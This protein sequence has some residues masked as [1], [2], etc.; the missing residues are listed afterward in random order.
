MNLVQASPMREKVMALQEVMRELPQMP[1]QTSHYF[2]DG[3]YARE[4]A[5][6]EGSLVVGKVHKREHLFI[7]LKG[8]LKVTIEDEVLVLSAPT[9]LVSKAGAKRALLALEDSIYLTVHKTKKKNLDKIER[10][11][12]EEDRRALFDSSNHIKALT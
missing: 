9:V 2:A 10:E 1:L 5:Q 3:M 4:L 8:S 7:V 11:L 12:I 6:P